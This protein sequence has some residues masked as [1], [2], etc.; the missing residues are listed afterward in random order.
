MTV[1]EIQ[2]FLEEQY[3]VEVSADLISTLT[4]VLVMT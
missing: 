1:L 2:R 4:D 3:E